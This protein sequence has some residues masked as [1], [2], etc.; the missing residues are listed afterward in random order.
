[1]EVGGTF[2]D[3]LCLDEAGRTQFV[4]VPSVPQRPDEGAYSALVEAGIDIAGIDELV[5]GSTVATNAVLERAGARV[6]FITTQGFRDILFMQRNNR[7]LV[8][9]LAYQ[10]PVPIVQRRDCFEVAERIIADGSVETPIDLD[11][12]EQALFP[13]L[14]N[15][16]Y[17][18]IA[19][20]LLN[21]YA[22]PTHERVLAELISHQLQD[23]V[24]TCS[25]DIAPEFREYE[26]AST[27]VIA[28][29][30][31]PVISEY[32]G[33]FKRYLES[34]GFAGSFS[35][36]QSNGGRLPSA[37]MRRNPV[38]AL[39]SGPAAGVMGAVRQAALSG[40][41]NLVTFDMG[42]TSTDVCLVEDGE[43]E[44]T[45]QTE[46]GG[47][48]VRTPL[49][50]IVS[51][52]AGCGSIV[53][54]D[55][56]GMLRV[57]PQ[58]AGADPGPACYGRGGVQPTITDAHII[59]GTIRPEAFLGGTMEVDALASQRV[60]ENV[61]AHFDMAL[62]EM[63]DSAIRL[64]DAN[65]VRAIQIISTERGRDPRDYVLVAF[66]GAGPLH[67]A[68]VAE[69][70][71]IRTILVPPFAGVLSA[72]GLLA[73]DYRLFET[74]T[75]RI[76]IEEN[77][78]SIV[79]ETAAEMQGHIVEHFRDI[80]LQER[81]LSFT[82][83]LEMRFVGQAFEVPVNIDP[84]ALDQLTV[85]GLLAAFAAAHQ[86]MYF[87]GGASGNPVE[88]VSFRLGA[89][90]PLKQAPML[91][92][93]YNDGDTIT[94]RH[95]IFDG[96]REVECKLTRRTGMSSSLDGPAII[97]DETSTIFVPAGWQTEIDDHEN[98]IMRRS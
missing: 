83:T 73:S 38:T 94:D 18:A 9:E 4:K 61:A 51:I 7:H 92:E 16:G 31:Q 90:S 6:A 22:N 97:D 86:R 82:L 71:D 77:A 24:V 52:G 55:E 81:E 15:G 84:T 47:L 20:C 50:D 23:L 19:I 37:G 93:T 53:W 11:A 66:G 30:V 48:P 26:R 59:Q 74:R 72:Y 67:A 49:F 88:V 96:S 65:I 68:R 32:I 33:R 29:H 69:D 95:H 41:D 57:G 46:I 39:F 10:K 36:M 34:N 40:Y 1:I 98:L 21:A 56:G 14:A 85:D 70:L 54:V 17:E 75:R 58:S 2:T 13:A 25:S 8:F 44:L 60:F 3:L 35:L 80:G 62:P 5:H 89:V 91:T 76:V 45:S 87:H 28:A 12:V 79:R 78:A 27:T 42:G 63:A 43:P 64:A